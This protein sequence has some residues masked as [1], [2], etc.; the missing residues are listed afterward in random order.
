MTEGHGTL[1]SR[2]AGAGSI[3]PRSRIKS[4][5]SLSQVFSQTETLRQCQ[6]RVGIICHFEEFKI[7]EIGN[8]EH[9]YICMIVTSTG[10][11]V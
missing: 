5:L 8:V 3:L 2:P 10:V 6:I 4:L 9:K 7:N 1:S 11:Y